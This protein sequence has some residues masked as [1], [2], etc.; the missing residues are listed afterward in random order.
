[1]ID[2]GAL[3][4]RHLQIPVHLRQ[5]ESHRDH[6]H[7]VEHREDAPEIL[8]GNTGDTR[9]ADDVAECGVGARGDDNSNEVNIDEI[10]DG[11]VEVMVT[12]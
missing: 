1:M 10:D 9:D 4:D 12:R 7:L 6:A 5:Q 8:G 11:K 3:A 2:I